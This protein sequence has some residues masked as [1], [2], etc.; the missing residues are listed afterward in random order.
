[1]DLSFNHFITGRIVSILYI[2]SLIVVTLNALIVAG[3]VSFLTGVFLE[4]RF[5]S[6]VLGWLVGILFFLIAFLLLLLLSVVYVRVLLEI[7]IVL[8]RIS[9]NTAEM[10]AG[11][12]EGSQ[13]FQRPSEVRTT[14]PDAEQ[15]T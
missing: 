14:R 15:E 3:Q 12:R 10:A 8:F 1:M 11:F 5:D 6:S 4:A 13:G 9:E 7:V 2:L